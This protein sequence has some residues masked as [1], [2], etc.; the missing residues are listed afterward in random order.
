MTMA[1]NTHNYVLL[2]RRCGR[3]VEERKNSVELRSRYIKPVVKVGVKGEFPRT[4]AV[5]MLRS[6]GATSQRHA[7]CRL[8]VF[9][10]VNHHG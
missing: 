10:L 9:S 2:A 8:D 3:G 1:L 5:V 7:V 6:S 4:L